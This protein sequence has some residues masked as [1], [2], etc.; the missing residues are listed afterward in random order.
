MRLLFTLFLSLLFPLT[1]AAYKAPEAASVDG[2]YSELIQV[3]NCPA[4]G[5]QYGNFKDYGH[6]NGGPWC[7]QQG[8]AGYWVWVAPNWY[9]WKTKGQA[10][11]TE[12][13]PMASVNG[14]YSGLIQVL[15]CPADSAQYGNFRDY[16]H[17][18]G[19]PWCG[20]QGKAGY[21]VW[22]KPN[23]YIWSQK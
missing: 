9:V 21:W 17:W 2:K 18:S 14:K 7:G 15:H 16:G 10:E 23:W 13:P 6:W 20:Q 3:L 19:G 22:V 1:A 8:K 11:K 4:D 5:A 12:V